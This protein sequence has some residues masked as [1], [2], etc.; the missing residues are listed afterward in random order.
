LC[1]HCTEISLKYS[2]FKLVDI[3]VVTLQVGSVSVAYPSIH[4][5]AKAQ[6]EHL[7]TDLESNLSQEEKAHEEDPTL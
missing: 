5:V 3:W 2:N 7:F 1:T 6:G 4:C